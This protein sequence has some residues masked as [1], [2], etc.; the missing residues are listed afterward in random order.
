MRV[1]VSVISAM[2]VQDAV[3][4]RGALGWEGLVPGLED[5]SKAFEAHHVCTDPHAVYYLRS[6]LDPCPTSEWSACHR[7]GASFSLRCIIGSAQSIARRSQIVHV[8]CNTGAV[9][10]RA[11][12]ACILR[13]RGRST[14]HVG[15]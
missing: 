4:K 6:Y 14:H 10:S 11:A 7:T 13:D 15:G 5:S 1:K 9:Q 3:H 8:K 2:Y 12:P